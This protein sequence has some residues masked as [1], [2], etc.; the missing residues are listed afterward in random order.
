[1]KLLEFVKDWPQG[2]D[3]EMPTIGL[4]ASSRQQVR[5][6]LILHEFS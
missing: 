6:P 3:G 2:R 5:L 4:L 1:M